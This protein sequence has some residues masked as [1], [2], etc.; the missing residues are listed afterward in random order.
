MDNK[1][2][3]KVLDCTLRD[4]GYVNNWE[5]GA[6][7]IG[8]I[9]SHLSNAGLDYIECG[10]LKNTDYDPNKTIFTNPNQLPAMKNLCLMVNYPTEIMP[11]PSDIILRVAFKK[12]DLQNALTYCKKLKEHGHKIFI[13]P[14][15]TDSYTETELIELI[16]EVN[17]IKPIALTIADTIGEMTTDDIETLFKTIDSRL[18]KDIALCFHSHNNIQMSFTNAKTL[19]ELC[20]TRDLIIDSSIFGMG[21]GAGNLCTELIAKHLGKYSMSEIM[22][23]SRDYIMPIYEKHPW[24]CS[25]KSYLAAINHCHPNYAKFLAE[26]NFSAKEMNRI[27]QSIP[28]DKKTV[29][30]KELIETL[31]KHV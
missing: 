1:I 27:F 19:I 13:N 30:D 4:G 26:K 31:I 12:Q 16:K 24:G 20:K 10:F 18:H 22:K 21:R 11:E 25:A 2:N 8:Q 7:N 17:K 28:D 6:E 3:I 15:V 29:F 9:I 14:M 5:F 23:V